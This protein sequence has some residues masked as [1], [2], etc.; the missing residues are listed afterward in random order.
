MA[1]TL[2]QRRLKKWIGRGLP[3]LA[4]IMFLRWFEHSQVYQPSSKIEVTPAHLG[5]PFEDVTLSSSDGKTLH[6]WFF[7]AATH[8][9][10]P[11]N[12]F[13]ICHGNGGNIS[14]RLPLYEILL[15][16]GAAVL[17]FD[18]RGYGQSSGRPD[19]EGT[20][21]DAQAAFQWLRR[22]GFAP[23]TIIAY[24]ESLGG[25]VAGELAMRE[26]VGG[27]ILQSSFTS[28]P[29]LGAELFPWLPV[30]WICRI[31]YN[32]RAKLP[33]IH[34]PVLILHSRS[35]SLIQF[36]HAQE[37]FAAANAPKLLIELTGDHNDGI[38]DPSGFLD[39]LSRFQNLLHP[40]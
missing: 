32:T 27:L 12:V 13:L 1:N 9:V 25:G 24:G 14:H 33:K 36:H 30:R 38:A 8:G 34:V 7:P 31:K 6:A 23:T 37:N 39:A 28:A 4:L 29:D 16:T 20:Y 19:E 22:K 40:K 11:S 18:Y 3:L 2:R 26:T 10:H 15:Q 35:D 21:R 17:A 5:R